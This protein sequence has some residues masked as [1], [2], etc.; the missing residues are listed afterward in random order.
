MTHRLNDVNNGNLD[1]LVNNC[2]GAKLKIDLENCDLDTWY[3]HMNLNVTSTFLMSQLFIPQ[4]SYNCNTDCKNDE[5]ENT[6]E[7][8]N[9]NQSSIVNIGSISG[10]RPYSGSFAY[11]VSKAAVDQITQCAAMELAP[12]KIRVNC[13]RPSTIRTDFH[14]N[15]GMS[16]SQAD[17]YYNSVGQFHMTT[18]T[19]GDV[20]D[21]IEMILF[22]ADN[23][24]S[25]WIT[26][27]SI[28]LDGGR[29]L[30][31]PALHNKFVGGDHE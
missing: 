22:L 27:Q 2:G 1:L 9:G 24:K 26:G 14:K 15:A 8:S 4:L 12:K 23:D 3:Y 5:N 21:V 6:R 7:N 10:I 16:Q 30:Q 11:C 13:I 17:G 25:K 31:T 18:N 19:V 28:T 29:L 20:N